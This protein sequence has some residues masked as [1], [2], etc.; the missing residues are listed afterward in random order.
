VPR[1]PELGNDAER[2]RKEEQ[3]KI[4]ES[5]VLNDEENAEKEDLLKQVGWVVEV[6]AKQFMFGGFLLGWTDFLVFLTNEKGRL[7]KT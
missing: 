7:T 3:A 2:I 1:N 5:E 6:Q 4:D